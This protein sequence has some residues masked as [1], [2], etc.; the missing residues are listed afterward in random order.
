M[1]GS[2]AKVETRR[3]KPDELHAAAVLQRVASVA[4]AAAA[5]AVATAAA[6]AVA[7]A[8]AAATTTTTTTTITITICFACTLFVL[9]VLYY[10]VLWH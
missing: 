5:V 7:T 8:A 3:L 9:Y 2:V 1:L 6:V 10:T 4:A